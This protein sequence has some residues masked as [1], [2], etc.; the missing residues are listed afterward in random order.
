M[1]LEAYDGRPERRRDVHKATKRACFLASVHLSSRIHTGRIL[2]NL[3]H[4]KGHANMH[5]HKR[6]AARLL[7]LGA[8][9]TSTLLAHAAEELAP[10][11]PTSPE[12]A[13]VSEWHRALRAGD[14]EAYQRISV[15][16]EESLSGQR[17]RFAEL[18]KFTPSE[19]KITPP[20]TFP[21]GN[22][23]LYVLGCVNG[24]RQ[25]AILTVVRD[26]SRPKVLATGW[27]DVWGPDLK[28]CP[29]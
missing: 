21:N 5:T 20:T 25:V 28:K 10:L 12:L 14:F 17:S 23:E 26:P 1:K 13:S 15:A 11:K 29:V 2:V 22:I 3:S 27:S 7:L 16:P 19:V 8:L 6:L 18:R 4:P 24:R 9:L